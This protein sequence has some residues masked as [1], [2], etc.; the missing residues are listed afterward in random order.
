[1]GHTLRAS[2]LV[3][4]SYEITTCLR[5]CCH[6]HTTRTAPRWMPQDLP[7]HLLLTRRLALLVDTLIAVARSIARRFVL[8]HLAQRKSRL[9]APASHVPSDVAAGFG[10]AAL[11]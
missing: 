3:V 6:S 5:G 10:V 4:N 8:I 1:M 9:R 2:T 7:R 11:I